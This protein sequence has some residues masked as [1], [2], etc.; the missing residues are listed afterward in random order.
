MIDDDI[1]RDDYSFLIY[2]YIY[3]YIY[4]HIHDRGFTDRDEICIAYVKSK[5]K[6]I[7]FMRIF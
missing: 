4:I 6:H 1:F 3:I 7:L 5:C 2:V